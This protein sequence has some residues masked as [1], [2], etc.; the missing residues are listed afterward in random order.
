[1]IKVGVVGFGYWGPNLVRNFQVAEE[2]TVVVVCDMSETQLARAKGMYPG[3]QTTRNFEALLESDVDAVVIATPVSTHFK[4]ASAALSKGKHVFV[5]KP[6]ASTVEECERLIE[7]AEAKNLVLHVDHTF[8]YTGAVKRIKEVILSGELGELLYYDS[9]RVNLGLFQHDVNVLWD[10]AVHD[11]S[12]LN[13]ISEKKPRAVSATAVSHLPNQP[14]NVAFLTVFYDEPLIAHI[15]V[16][17][18]APVR[19]EEH[20]SELQSR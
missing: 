14:E 16:N 7:Q 17:W 1:M 11:L 5:E 10:L 15:N 19:S 3:L 8:V 4:L 18:L 20:T 9:T 13:V 12:I 2:S 6:M